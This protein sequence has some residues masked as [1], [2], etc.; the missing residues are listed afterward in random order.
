M[1]TE[2]YT[3]PN[4]EFTKI[5]TEP[6]IDEMGTN[7]RN[8]AGL[9]EI[10]N[11]VVEISQQNLRGQSSANITEIPNNYSQFRYHK[12]AH[13]YLNDNFKN[14]EFGHA[15]S[16]CDR[17]WFKKDLKKPSASGN[18]INTIINGCPENLLYL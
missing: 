15:C 9:G 10:K 16:I 2:L 11:V 7:A 1:I 5:I 4:R 12:S 6:I 17:L 13:E 18:V 8:I 14:N 3:S